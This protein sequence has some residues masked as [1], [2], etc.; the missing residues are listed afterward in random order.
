MIVEIN[1]RE[2]DRIFWALNTKI[3]QQ[4]DLVAENPQERTY[5][6]NVEELTVISNKIKRITGRLQATKWNY[7]SVG[8]ARRS[9]IFVDGD[10]DWEDSFAD[11]LEEFPF[12]G[13]APAEHFQ[14]EQ[15]FEQALGKYRDERERESFRAGFAAGKASIDQHSPDLGRKIAKNGSN[16]KSTLVD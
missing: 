16:S 5:V 8:P 13:S 2:L 10:K 7:G 6:E 15:E 9:L 4:R 3:Q 12:D 1:G 11:F 14:T